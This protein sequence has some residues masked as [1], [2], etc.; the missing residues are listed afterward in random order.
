M[1]EPALLAAED[2]GKR[3]PGV[4]ALAGVSFE[5]R[6]GEV[7]ALCGENGAGKSTLIKILCGVHPHGSYE[8]RMH[9]HGEEARFRSVREA[10]RA[11]VTVI[12]QELALVGELSVAENLFLGREPRRHGLIDWPTLHARARDL[13]SRFGLEVD[14]ATPCGT[15]GVGEQQLVEI[16]RAL[17]KRTAALILDEPTAALADREV[18]VLLGVMRELRRDG[19]GCLFVSHR[20]EEVFRIADRVTVLRDGRSVGTLPAETTDRRELIRRMVGREL[21]D[22][23]PRR[24]GRPGEVRLRV[25]GLSVAEQP[26]G[27]ARLRNIDLDARAGEV[28]GIGGLMGAGRTE[29]LM[30][31]FGAWGHRLSGEVALDDGPPASAP[32][33][34]IRRGVGL[35]TEDR[36]R[37]GLV[38]DQSVGFNLSLAS[39]RLLRRGPFVD[40]PGEARRNQASVRELGIRTP[41]L[42]TPVKHLSGGNQQ[43]V[44]LGKALM[45]SPH[46]VLLDEP[47]RGVDVGAKAELYALIDRMTTEGRA[48]VLASSE[49]PE[50]MGLADRIVMLH[51]GSIGGT[52]RR[53]EA[54]Q[55]RLL[56]AAMGSP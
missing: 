47:T 52:F 37:L 12:H 45:P 16:A 3:F 25:R 10:E 8:G 18:E 51:E 20:L 24:T 32:A 27:T 2:L 35:V 49:L 5:L 44:V 21:G 46:V 42:D 22:L 28:L 55:E 26:G 7:H 43:K 40:A 38:L 23:F 31:L 6:A 4:T 36:K 14:P 39:L 17:G 1:N 48:V 15:L 30:H 11:G 13:L 29:L 53:E 34:A 33:E 19:I 41:G 50:L 9:V 56:A 54:T